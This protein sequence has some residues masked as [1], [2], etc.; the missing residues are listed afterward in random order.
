MLIDQQQPV[1]TAQVRETLAGDGLLRWCSKR[2]LTQCSVRRRMF[3]NQTAQPLETPMDEHALALLDRLQGPDGALGRRKLSSVLSDFD[4]GYTSGWA[5]DVPKVFCRA[6]GLS[7]EPGGDGGNDSGRCKQSSAF[8]FSRG[9]MLYDTRRANED[10]AHA[11]ICVQVRAAT[12]VS[13]ATETTPR[14]PGMVRFDLHT[15][16]EDR[17]RFVHRASRC[18]TQDDFVRFLIAGPP[19]EWTDISE[20]YRAIGLSG[21]Q[22][23]EQ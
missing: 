12:S 7:F 18:T 14:N 3:Q 20:I 13:R 22:E 8:E 19:P 4:D 15:Q 9:D 16:S 17:R 5:F 23:G 21:G 2:A 10:R 1:G 6:L 11:K